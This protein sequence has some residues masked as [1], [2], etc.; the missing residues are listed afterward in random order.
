MAG[1]GVVDLERAI[2]VVDGGIEEVGIAEG[3]GIE[4]V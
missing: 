1:I 4:F 3:V 2:G